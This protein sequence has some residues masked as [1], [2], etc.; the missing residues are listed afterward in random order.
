MS[1]E[2]TF[3]IAVL[4]GGPGGYVAAIR[5]AQAGLSV[6][7]VEQDRLGGIC[8]NWGCIPSKSL[9]ASAHLFERL[10]RASEFGISAGETEFDW[11]AIVKRSRR[12]SDRAAR[13]VSYLMKKNSIQ[14]FQGRGILQGSGRIRIEE[15]EGSSGNREEV[16]S[17][18]N[19]ILALGAKPRQIPGIEVDRT[20]VITSREALVLKSI[21]DSIVIVGAGAIGME[22]AYLFKTFG[23][24]VTVVELLERIL[25][26]ED[27]EISG[28]LQKLYQR[29]GMKFFTGSGVREITR[30]PGAGISVKVKTHDG[31]LETV[32]CEKVLL[33]VGVTGNIEDAG[34]EAA[35]VE[36]DNG[37]IRVDS[38][39]RTTARGVRAIGDCI[40]APLLA[41]AASREGIAAVES[42]L[43]LEVKPV[44][45]ELVP[46]CTYC[47]PQVACVGLTE[48][49]ALDAGYEVSVG[50][51][52][53]RP[54]GK[55]LAE[56]EPDGFVKAVVD[57]KS[58]LLL[59][60]H[61]L[62]SEAT[63]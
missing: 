37:F 29:R 32:D 11:E 7:L 54:L 2:I 6:A 40:G 33:A 42:I 8:L 18:E 12:V 45:A 36:V 57:K 23:S 35:G 5:A 34:L 49:A 46:G 16:I 25:P 28:E 10:N 55:A 14:V 15:D 41:H 13:G 9:L 59:G 58:G 43:G 17:A 61:I 53:F 20:V 63:E 4:G 47:R 19:I 62:G 51:F 38:G 50:R 3:D 56:G 31:T 21:P 27:E 22:F 60:V 52:P 1:I 26:L 48:A 30:E 24:R 39:F 44:R